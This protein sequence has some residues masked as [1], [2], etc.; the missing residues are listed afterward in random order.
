MKAAETSIQ[1]IQYTLSTHQAD[2]QGLHHEIKGVSEQVGQAVQ[3]A[4]HNHKTEV[5]HE[6]ESRFDRLEALFS[7]KKQ[8]CE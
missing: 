1:G 4:L 8:R 7:N 3:S 2:L 5:S 6:L